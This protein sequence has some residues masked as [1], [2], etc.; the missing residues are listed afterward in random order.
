MTVSDVALVEIGLNKFLSVHILMTNRVINLPALV[1]DLNFIVGA[2]RGVERAE[3]RVERWA[4][5]AEKRWSKDKKIGW[6]GSGFFAAHA[7]LTCS[8]DDW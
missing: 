3:N 8:G 4:G 6:C 1:P 2:K 5:V 7:T